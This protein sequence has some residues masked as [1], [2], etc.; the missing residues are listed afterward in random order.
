MRFGVCQHEKAVWK[1]LH[2]TDGKDPEKT[3]GFIKGFQ[4]DIRAAAAHPLSEEGFCGME[5]NGTRFTEKAEAGEAILAVCKA[6]QDF[7]GRLFFLAAIFPFSNEKACLGVTAKTDFFYRLRRHREFALS[8]C[9][10]YTLHKP[11]TCYLLF[12]PVGVSGR[13]YT[14]PERS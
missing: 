5:V 9:M 10:L 14:L 13:R 11:L 12:C 3:Q 8:R 7:S 4:S 2:Q 1:V 6:N